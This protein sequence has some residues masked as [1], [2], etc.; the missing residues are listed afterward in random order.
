MSDER[1]IR[2]LKLG[3]WIY[4]FLLIFE[5]ALRKW[6]LPGL[7]A[8]LLIVRDP[9]AIWL[10]YRT[11]STGIWK[12]NGYVA[13][14]FCATVLSF[15]LALFIGHGNIYV[16]L[17]GFRITAI[18]FPLIFIIGRILDK[19]DVIKMGRITL[20]ITIGMTFLVAWQFFSPQSAW[21]NRGVGGDIEG[22]GFGGAAGFFRVPG[23]FSF[24]N[25]LSFF[26]GLATVFIFFFWF[27]R[28]KEVSKYLLLAA[29]IALVAAIPLSI[30]RTVF[31]QIALTFAFTLAI[32]SKNP[33]VILRLF[34]VAIVGLVCL[35]ILS[36]FSFFQTAT[37]AFQERFTSANEIEGGVVEGVFIDRFLGGM[38]GELTKEQFKFW[39]AGL[40]MGTNAG[41]QI[42][43]GERGFLLAEAEWGRLVG[44]MGFIFGLAVILIRGGVAIQLVKNAWDA[45]SRENILPWLLASFGMFLIIQGQWA[46]PTTLGFSVLIGGLI[47]AAHSED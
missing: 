8:P 7:S 37:L 14:I 42:L 12:P 28:K 32:A 46:Q 11:L 5:G 47:I 35:V 29:T 21:V 45:I 20:W 13:L 18:H 41:A 22:S 2:Q 33:K 34:G 16:A 26:Y 40:G 38:Y 9:I 17:Y 24:T 43:V 25:G 6:V 30:S 27:S 36:N 10:I 4:F 15:V 44:E 3:V 1:I 23:T 19:E 31:F 39:G